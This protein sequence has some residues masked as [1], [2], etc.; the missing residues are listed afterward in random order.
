MLT[1]LSTFQLKTHLTSWLSDTFCLKNIAGSHS[2][3]TWQL[4]L[5][6]DFLNALW[7]AGYLLRLQRFQHL[8]RLQLLLAVPPLC[9][10]QHCHYKRDNLASHSSA[11]SPHTNLTATKK[12]ICHASYC[13][14]SHACIFMNISICFIHACWLKYFT[15]FMH[16]WVTKCYVKINVRPL[17]VII[18]NINYLIFGQKGDSKGSQTVHFFKIGQ[19]RRRV[20]C[21][22]MKANVQI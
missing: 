20:I 6:A 18:L 11:F 14:R 7:S 21:Q 5:E 12:A 19:A 15:E 16:C 17:T 9:L 3:T 10:G 1:H 4:A 13:N 22:Q 2:I 8:R